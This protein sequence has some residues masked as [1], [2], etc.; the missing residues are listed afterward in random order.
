T[1]RSGRRFAPTHPIL[2]PQTIT[3]IAAAGSSLGSRMMMRQLFLLVACALLSAAAAERPVLAQDGVNRLRIEWEVKNR[4][5]LFRSE[6]DFL[7]HVSVH[8]DD[9]LLGAEDRLAR[10]SGGRGWARDTVE[11]L[12]TDRAGRLLET[13]DRDGVRENYLA[14]RDH[15]VGVVVAGPAAANL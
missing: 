3:P 15:P 9:G 12:C 10:D 14:P 13:C 6:S 5:R 11:R 1:T 2:P 7:R 4:F 8:R